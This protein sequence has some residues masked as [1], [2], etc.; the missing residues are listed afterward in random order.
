MP[1]SSERVPHARGDEPR[2]FD[3]IGRKFGVFPTHVG[4]N[5]VDD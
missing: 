1:D 2:T 5:R 3:E 4:M